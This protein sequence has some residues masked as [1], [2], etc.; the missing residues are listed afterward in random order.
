MGHLTRDIRVI[1]IGTYS[2]IFVLYLDSFSTMENHMGN[3]METTLRDDVGVEVMHA[4]M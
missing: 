1:I 3:C 2:G 4:D